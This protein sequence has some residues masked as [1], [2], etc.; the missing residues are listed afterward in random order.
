[1]QIIGQLS[2]TYGT[3][4]GQFQEKDPQLQVL[5]L[6]KRNCEIANKQPNSAPQ[7]L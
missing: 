5:T 7:V 6:K 1:M 4:I 2:R 3:Q